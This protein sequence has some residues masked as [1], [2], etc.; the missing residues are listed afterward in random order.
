MD[1]RTRARK[2]SR[3][4]TDGSGSWSRSCRVSAG[5]QRAG[6]AA[7]S[8]MGLYIVRTSSQW[9]R[10]RMI[11]RRGN[12]YCYFRSGASGIWEQ[13]LRAAR[14]DRRHLG[15]RNAQRSDSRSHRE[16]SQKGGRGLRAH[17]QVAGANAISCDTRFVLKVVV[18]A[19]D[20]Q[21]AC[22]CG[23]SPRP[24]APLMASRQRLALAAAGCVEIVNARGSQA[25][26]HRTLI[27]RPRLVSGFPLQ[28]TI[29]SI[30]ERSLCGMSHSAA[31]SRRSPPPLYF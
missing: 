24:P 19:A 26:C 27:Q 2:L 5:R 30:E 22:G 9:R 20:V 3:D 31:A 1:E 14:T 10:C 13:I 18:S 25:P 21:T 12:V 17:K 28:T 15:A 4:L 16:D 7:R 8:S 6:T 11:C 29:Q 23:R